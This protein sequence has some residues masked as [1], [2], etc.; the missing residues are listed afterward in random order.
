LTTNTQESN[1]SLDQTTEEPPLLFTR[2]ELLLHPNIP[3]PLHGLAPRTLVKAKEWNEIRR[4]AYGKNNYHCWACGVYRAYDL[5]NLRFD[6]DFGESLDAHES[7]TI[8]YKAKTVELKEI[9]ALCKNCHN[10][11]HSGRLNSMFEKGEV[12]A[13]DCWIVYTHGD[14]VLI[15]GGLIPINTVD[16]KTYQEEWGEWKLLFR[17]KDYGSIWKDYWDWYKHYMIG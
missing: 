8:D 16:E 3:K 17:G 7:Y 10:Y 6:N 5:A 1:K 11:V 9:V 15:D 13:E 4:E 14:S 2:P 12:D